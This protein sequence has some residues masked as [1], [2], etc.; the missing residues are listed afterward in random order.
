MTFEVV[1]MLLAVWDALCLVSC[2][3]EVLFAVG[4]ICTILGLIKGLENANYMFIAA[5]KSSSLASE[6]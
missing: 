4:A 1:Q 3:C 5:V 2:F 6:Y